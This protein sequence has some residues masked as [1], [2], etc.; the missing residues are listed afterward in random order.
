MQT[1]L[2]SNRD[3]MG[4]IVASR[5]AEDLRSAIQRYGSAN[6]IVATGASQFEVLSNLVQATDIDWTRVYGFHLDEYAGLSPDHPASFCRYLKERFVDLVKL[7]D[8]QFLYGDQDPAA[9]IARV[10]PLIAKTRI[11]VALVGI[12]E[13]GHLA[14]NDPPA[15]FETTEPYLCVE[16]DQP[17]RMQQVGEGWFASLED[18]PTHAISMSVSQ[19]LK[20]A[21]IYCSVPD[22]Q[23]AVAVAATIEGPITPDV[24]ASVL[25]RHANTILVIDEASSASLRS[26]T[27][28][29][30]ERVA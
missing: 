15:D 8:F 14:F 3:T 17:C 9:T 11:D 6:L 19:I 21:K 25:K 10:S 29:E 30:L 20:S 16:L 5:A 23:K 2:T 1:I 18:V 13:N 27:R 28:S 4:R 24:P 26:D 12:G 22:S 7:A